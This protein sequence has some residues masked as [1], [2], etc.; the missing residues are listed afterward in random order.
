MDF[1]LRDLEIVKFFIII[2][3]VAEGGEQLLGNKTH[4]AESLEYL[5]VFK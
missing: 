1:G 5:Y 2:H 4:V 3:G